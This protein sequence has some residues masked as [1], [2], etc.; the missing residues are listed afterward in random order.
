MSSVR[1]C[2]AFALF[3]TLF[4]VPGIALAQLGSNSDVFYENVVDTV[5]GVVGMA[6]SARFVEIPEGAGEA[7]KVIT[8]PARDFNFREGA[9][10]GPISDRLSISEFQVYIRSDNDPNGLPRRSGAILIPASAMESFQ[11]FKIVARSDAET[12]GGN[13][14][15]DSLTIYL[16][17]IQL[18]SETIREPTEGAAEAV[19][20]F[21][22]LPLQF[23]IEEPVIEAGFPG[24]I[25]DYF[26]ILTEATVTFTSSDNQSLFPAIP[27]AS[28]ILEL[29]FANGDTLTY[30]LEFQ[31][32]VVP[33][34]ASLI[35]VGVGLASI[36]LVARK[37][38]PRN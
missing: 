19:L 24:V 7:E 38:S 33:E 13:G 15:S 30:S 14:E 12:V 11:P 31:S 26:D 36:A 16:R 29:P 32:D 25:S 28:D 27:T 37:R 17:G 5:G 1:Q 35:L 4:L 6:P 21:P 18:Y 3:S 20:S 2:S 34:P 10:D 22:I 8:I 9:W 23:D